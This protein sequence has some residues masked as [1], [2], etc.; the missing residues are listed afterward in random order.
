MLNS[1]QLNLILLTILSLSQSEQIF[2]NR[3]HS[4]IDLSNVAQALPVSDLGSAQDFLSKYGWIKPINW[5]NSQYQNVPIPDNYD[6]AP[7]D[8][9]ELMQEGASLSREGSTQEANPTISPIYIKAV[10]QFQEANGLPITGEINEATINVMNKPRCGVPDKENIEKESSTSNPVPTTYNNALQLNTTA[11]LNGNHTWNNETTS[12][13]A[14]KKRLLQMLMPQERYK[15]A[16]DGLEDGGQAF[17]KKKLKWRLIDEGYSNQFTIDEQRYI[18]RLAFRMWSEVTPLEFEEDLNS[19]QST[20]DIKLGF[21]TGRHLGCS[22]KFDGSGHEFAHAWLLGDIHFDDDEHF[23]APKSDNG[24]SLLKVAA[25]EIGH[26]L[27]LPHIYRTGSIM[28]PNYIPQ[29]EG[30]ELDR[31]DRKAIQQ[32]YGICDGPFDVIFDWVRKERNKHGELVVRFNTYFFRDSWYWLYENRNNRTRYGDP[33]TLKIGWHGIPAGGINAF[34]HI[35]TWTKDAAYFFKGTQYWR[36]D[37]END[38]A[39]TEDSQGYKYPRLISEGFPGVTNPIDTA[40]YDRRDQNIYFFKD[41]TV[42]AFN[43]NKN[44]IVGHPR[45]IT[46]AFP[47]IVPNDHPGGNL[48]S[49]YY[50]YTYNSIFFLKG[51]YFWKV[52]SD[53]DRQHNPSLPYNGLFPKR[54]IASQWFDLCNVHASMLKIN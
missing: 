6:Q 39:Y 46:E 54:S 32:L 5:E 51:N 8:I 13:G 23:T 10:K 50:S 16:Q 2:Y 36:Y 3:D 30:F 37:N 41:S 27:G 9:T 31:L 18:F 7:Q 53:R 14:H 12:T 24:I 28:Q 17:S 15:R 19:H 48:N 20:I 52:V 29:E 44:Q 4:D 21:G 38:R 22:Q 49:A 47:A 42:F 35:W 45:N 40:F 26:V 43:V 25:H 1:L 11:L 33:I 34:V